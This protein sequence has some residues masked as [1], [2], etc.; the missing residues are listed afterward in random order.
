[1][2]TREATKMPAPTSTS[3]PT[4]RRRISLESS[5]FQDP[6]LGPRRGLSRIRRCSPASGD[7]G[8]CPSATSFVA[9][10]ST[11]IAA[12]LPFGA[13]PDAA[14]ALGIKR[15]SPLPSDVGAS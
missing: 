10:K 11:G 12:G 1:M 9:K 13:E 8:T 7:D 3:P 6:D 4:S 5:S 14:S 2:R 15:A